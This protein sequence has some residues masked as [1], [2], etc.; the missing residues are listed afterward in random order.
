MAAAR[1][2]QPSF[3]FLTGADPSSAAQQTSRLP[4]ASSTRRTSINKRQSLLGAPTIPVRSTIDNETLRAQL[5]ALQYELETLRQD[6]AMEVE[7]LNSEIRD[8]ER[9]V[10]TEYKRAQEAERVRGMVEKRLEES[11]REAADRETRVVNE[12]GVLE[13][14]LRTAIDEVRG[15]KEDVEEGKAEIEG[16]RREGVRGLRDLEGRCEALEKRV[17]AVGE[18]RDAAVENARAVS[19]RLAEKERRVGDLEQEVFKLKALTGDQETLSVVKREL[20]EQVSHIKRLEKLNGEMNAELKRLRRERKAVEV[21]EEEKRAL[22]GK[23]GLLDDARRELSESEIKRQMLED[24]RRAWAAYLDNQQ[25]EA[26]FDS[27]EEMARA[28]VQ[29][30]VERVQLMEKLGEVQ[31]EL[32]VKD[33]VI[34]GLEL[35]KTKLEAEVKKLKTSGTDS[36]PAGES[37]ARARLERQRM[38]AV[39]EVE[40]LRAQLKSLEDETTE[41]DPSKAEDAVSSRTSELE[42]LI[43]QYKTEISSLHTQ[44][45]NLESQTPAAPAPSLKRSAPDSEEN[46]ALGSLRRKLRKMQDALSSVETKN[47]ALA[48]DLKASSTQLA[49][50]RESS[51]TRVLEYSK[52]PTAQYEAVKMATLQTLRSENDALLAQL[53]NSSPAPAM[54]PAAVLDA[55]KLELA[56]KDSQMAQKDKKTLRLK[57]IWSAKA[58]EFRDAI[59][60]TLGWEVT[61]LEHGKLKLSSRYYSHSINLETKEEEENFILFDGERGTMKISGG[62]RSRFAREIQEM[63][64]FWVG[65]KGEVP[66]FLAAASLEFFERNQQEK[67][68]DDG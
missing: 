46:E 49:A 9:R 28:F 42:A 23:L 38:L 40:Y 5:N 68:K 62:E 67:E 48:N 45:T 31:P 64:D 13:K 66:C 26:A 8:A 15:L 43:D 63:V 41:F 50:L 51:R 36:G 54:V 6:R 52:N 25:G 56:E 47:A 19:E 29:E 7:N 33:E 44:L 17:E 37:K 14:K 55:M 57:Q 1:N 53:R 11:R 20:G 61:F 22:E 4:L 35:E 12:R 30:R 60:S 39:K 34:N 27:P 32:A 24:E 58:Q 16:L 2:Q 18:E 59:S 65:G 3:D 10:E 21:V